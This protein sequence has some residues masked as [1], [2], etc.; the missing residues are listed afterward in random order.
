M[1]TALLQ[2]AACIIAARLG[3]TGFTASHGYT[4]GF[5]ARNDECNVAMHGEAG[6]ANLAAAASAV[7]KI[8]LNLEGYPPDRIYNLDETGLL[9]RCLPSRSYVPRRNRRHARGTKAMRQKGRITLVLR[10][11][12]TAAHKLPESNIGQA[13]P[14]ICFRGEGN[15]CPLLYFSQKRARKDKHVYDR[16]WATV[17]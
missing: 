5:L 4:R 9:Y 2:E 16:W 15:A 13:A 3:V 6:A 11:N 7:E 8:R 17:F 14:P 12:A 10:A 1:T